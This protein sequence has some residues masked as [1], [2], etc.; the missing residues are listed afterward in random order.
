MR[1]LFQ[2]SAGWFIF[3]ICRVA[4]RILIRWMNWLKCMATDHQKSLNLQPQ[5]CDFLH[6]GAVK[7]LAQSGVSGSG[8]LLVTNHGFLSLVLKVD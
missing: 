4:T 1:G 8:N 5:T 7:Y 3:P 2:T 6:C